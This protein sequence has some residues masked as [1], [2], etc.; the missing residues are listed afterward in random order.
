VARPLAGAPAHV[1]LRGLGS[2][3][4]ARV[5][6]GLIAA[7]LISLRRRNLALPT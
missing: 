4:W 1:H 5:C 7:A 6:L 3:R 2:G